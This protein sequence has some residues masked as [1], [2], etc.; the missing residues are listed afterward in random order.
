MIFRIGR[1]R[2]IKPAA[3]AGMSHC[4]I[5][6]C[7][8]PTMRAAGKGL[9]A[10]HCK[11]HVDHKA[12]HGSHWKGTYLATDLRP[13]VRAATTWLKANRSDPFVTDAIGALN[14][15]LKAAG[16]AEIA[17]RLRGLPPKR[18]AEIA[19][20]RLREAGIEPERILGIALGTAALIEDDPNSHRVREFRIVQ[21][22]KA[23]HRLASGYHRTWEMH[24]N[25]GNTHPYSIH[26]YPRSSGRV[27]RYMGEEIERA[28]ELVIDRHLQAVLALK[29]ERFGPL[30]PH[31]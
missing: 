2:Q 27:L 13:Y 8:K 10:F 31:L 30:V 24:G 25:D 14:G 20:A 26:A 3:P 1:G 5:P 7:G 23:A 17:T 16:P 22:A 9:A 28:C 6:G 4:A 12:R 21:T 11:A 15:I 18:R 29:V 19:F